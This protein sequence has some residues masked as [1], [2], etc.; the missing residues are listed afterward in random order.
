M[1]K[2]LSAILIIAGLVM[3]DVF[4][5]KQYA[6]TAM[7]EDE[8]NEKETGADRQMASLWWSR[9]YPEPGDINDKFYKGWLHAKAMRET[10]PAYRG[11]QPAGINVFS[12]NWMGIGP[13]QNIGGRILCIAVDPQNSN[14]LFAGSASGGIWKSYTGGTG[15]TAWQPLYTGF[16]VLGVSSI[17]IDPNNSNVMYAG[18]GEVYRV[19]TSNIGFNVWKARGTYGV[20]II[21]STDRGSSWTQVF[22]KNMSGLFG[23]QMLKFDPLNSNIVYACTTD[24]LYRSVNA[25]S[26]WTRILSKIYV[27]DIAI[28]PTNTNQLVAAVGNLQNTDKGIYRS[29]DGGVNWTKI[30][31]GLPASFEG[32]IRL[33][34]VN[35]KMLYCLSWKEALTAG[36]INALRELQLLMKPVGRHIHTETAMLPFA[37]QR[38]CCTG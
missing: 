5:K 11:Q 3:L 29:V 12:G 9:A 7:R 27:S 35:A 19:D 34:N 21:K 30:T 17:I 22:N 38:M 23:V 26:T 1:K 25:G 18:T 14:N 36:L 4:C 2:S 33:D 20:G 13:S 32:F 24:G 16:P 10:G 28:H 8:E 15:T 37:M 31:S 6:E